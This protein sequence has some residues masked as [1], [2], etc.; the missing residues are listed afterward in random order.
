MVTD[1]Q[2]DLRAGKIMGTVKKMSAASKYEVKYPNGVAGIRGT[3]YVIDANGVV[4]V[5]SGTVLVSWVKPDGSAG[6]QQVM[7]GYSFDPKTGQMTKLTTAEINEIETAA[8][9]LGTGVLTTPSSFAIDQ[10]VYYVS[11][12]TGAKPSGSS[13]GG[14]GG[15][16]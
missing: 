15:S 11:P 13:G 6:T 16:K 9:R 5:L 1:T 2:L 8:I 12:T 7:A 4:T 10:T 3:I 14:G